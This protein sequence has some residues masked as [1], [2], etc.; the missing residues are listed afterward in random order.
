M[1]GLPPAHSLSRRRSPRSTPTQLRQQSSWPRVHEYLIAYDDR[2]PPMA[3]H[4]S[5]K[6]TNLGET[7]RNLAMQGR[8]SDVEGEDGRGRRP[9]RK[10]YFPTKNAA[11]CPPRRWRAVT[12]TRIGQ[13]L[14][15]LPRREVQPAAKSA[16]PR[17]GWAAG[18]GSAPRRAEVGARL[19][20]VR[21][22]PQSSP[23]HRHQTRRTS[24]W[25]THLM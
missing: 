22:S 4:S 3:A 5:A 17:R 11:A 8:V 25:P 10:I 13:P 15:Q 18:I 20:M 2:C 21:R 6:R 7:T 9:S 12:A 19:E 24:G 16:R 1:V 23:T 14:I